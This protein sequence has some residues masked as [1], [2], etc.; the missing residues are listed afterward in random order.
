MSKTIAPI[1]LLTLVLTGCGGGGGASST[2]GGGY[3]R[4]NVPYYTPT[5]INH[6][7]PVVTSVYSTPYT[8]IFAKDLNNDR[9]D[10][11]VIS[12][13]A[14]GSQY[15]LGGWKNSNLQ[16][17]GFNTG[18]FKNETSTWIS[19][20][21]N[22]YLGGTTI[23]FGDFNGDG[24]TDMFATSFSDTNIHAPMPVLINNGNNRFTRTNIDFG[25]VSAHDSTVVDLNRD[26]YADIIVTDIGS[27][28][29][30]VA[31]GSSTGNF[32]VY[33]SDLLGG[34]AGISVADYLGNGTQTM[35][36][37]DT[38]FSNNGHDD[39][40][41]FSWSISNGKLVLTKIA[42]LPPDRF[43][44][45]KWASVVSQSNI[46]PHAVRNITM[47]FNNDGRPD[48]VVFSTMPKNG[49]THGYSEVQ[50]LKNNGAG[51]FT[52]V[53]DSVLVNYNTNKTTTYNPQLIDVNN[54]GL[55][56]ILVS[57]T[58][59]TGQASTSVLLATREGKFVESYTQVFTS[60]ANQTKTL[61][62]GGQNQ[63]ITIVA[64]PNGKNYLMTGVETADRNGTP[65]IA[66]YLSLIGSTG[67]VTAPA[68]VAVVQQAWPWMSAAEANEALAKSIVSWVDGMPVL[69]LASVMRPVGS[70]AISLSGRTGTRIPIAGNLSVP[71]L[72]NALLNNIQAVDS[73]NRNFSVNLI[74]MAVKP[75][76]IPIRYNLYSAD[77]TQNW[78]S[79][80]TNAENYSHNG[81][82]ISGD[83][84]SAYS[85]SFTDR[86]LNLN[87]D[88]NWN[89]RVGIA[90][91]PNI[92]PWMSITGMFGNINKTTMV[93]FNATRFWK[94]GVFGQ[95]GLI[96]SIVDFSPGLV[97]KITPLRLGYA[98]AGWKSNGFTLYGGIQPTIFDGSIKVKLPSSVDTHGTM[99]YT[100]H[101]VTIRNRPVS[102]VGADRTWKVGKHLFS[103]A[104]VINEQR[105]YQAK[106]S[107]KFAF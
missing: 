83:G 46:A 57:A 33:R 16:I 42:D 99:H 60:F 75:M 6:Y 29:P 34:A 88:K 72:D 51:S 79:R 87:T 54:D 64:G 50:F 94:N 37:T 30:A 2:Y 38:A 25:N 58:D 66:V 81:M 8:E 100:Q 70:L 95:I 18:S 82:D 106:A 9:V 76:D 47:D 21:D 69:D 17:Y 101:D 102:F 52:D 41:L 73:L 12:S 68:T 48:V 103:L 15:S 97:E 26:G 10:E 35:V 5:A 84:Q 105:S 92:N 36:L 1:F 74:D 61:A 20:T 40:R 107:V 14:F 53:T 23:R 31:F 44:L 4:P 49:N 43:S 91:L 63:S 55:V 13:V 19:G 24:K 59:Y 98:V 7:S 78:S 3:L 85:L 27:Q 71:G 39:T 104:A 56:D 86:A 67:T 28:R 96:Q 32:T 22:Q 65:Q 11:V 45:P 80:F 93:D 77:V 90:V 62:G 89:L